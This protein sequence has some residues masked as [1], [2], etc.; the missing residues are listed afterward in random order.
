MNLKVSNWAYTYPFC[1]LADYPCNKIKN[2][3]AN[4]VDTSE[5]ADFQRYEKS[6]KASDIFLLEISKLRDTSAKRKNTVFAID[7]H[8]NQIYDT[9]LQ[10]SE[11]F[12]AQ[13]N[14]FINKAKSYGFTV[15]DMEPVFSNHYQK[16][17]QKFEFSNDGHWNSIGHKVVSKEIAKR[18][19]LMPKN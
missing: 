16:N 8:R 12:T 15:I 1:M 9:S 10:K 14:Y 7:A 5:S 11:Y 17:K 4:I 3:K 6:R 19:D 18:L 2:F 13:R